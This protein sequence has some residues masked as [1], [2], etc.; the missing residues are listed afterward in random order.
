MN[1]FGIFPKLNI[2][3]SQGKRA[4]CGHS[5]T[6]VD[7]QVDQHLWKLGGIGE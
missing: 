2:F 1:L 6:G 7:A 3:R 4:P 5:I